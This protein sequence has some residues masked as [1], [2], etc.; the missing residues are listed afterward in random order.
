MK[1]M[2]IR[3][4][5]EDQEPENQIKDIETISGK[6][7]VLF[8][9]K[10]SAWRDDKERPSFEKLKKEIQF[11]K[12]KELYVWDWDRLFRN[13]KKLKDFFQFCTLYKCSIHSF[14]Q[15]FYEDFYKIPS[16]FNEIVQNIVLDLLGWI[17][18]DESKKKSDRVKLAVRKEGGITKSYKGNKWGRKS[19]K[20]DKN[21]I[22]LY[23]QGK[24]MRD[25]TKE[26][27]YW[28]KSRHKKFVSL[29]YVHKV[30][31]VHKSTKKDTPIISSHEDS[32]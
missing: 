25:I 31:D 3:T 22:D 23:N 6:D 29:G 15:A 19:L 1:A 14:R 21:I 26:I 27:Y 28:D 4:S 20:I 13:R 12:V 16:P 8:Q 11:N 2:Y 24:S 30:I 9:D 18:E 5:T 10:Q 17:A 32:S 7:Y